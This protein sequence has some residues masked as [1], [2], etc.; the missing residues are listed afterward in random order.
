MNLYARVNQSN[1]RPVRI[2]NG[3]PNSANGAAPYQPRPSAGVTGA[4]REVKRAESPLYR[5]ESVLIP[6]HAIAL[7]QR[8]GW[9]E[10]APR[11]VQ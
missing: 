5:L 4:H 3:L 7:L 9:T 1:L 8:A 11:V 6:L 10:P 2:R